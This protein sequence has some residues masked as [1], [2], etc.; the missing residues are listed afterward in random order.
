MESFFLVNL[1]AFYVRGTLIVKG[2]TRLG[3][4]F[5]AVEIMHWLVSQIWFK[6]EV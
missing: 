3:T 6:S 4:Y 2:L 5:I 1:T